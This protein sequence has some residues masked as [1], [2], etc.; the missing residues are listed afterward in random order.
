MRHTTSHTACYSAGHRELQSAPLPSQGASKP[1]ET[2][3]AS[4]GSQVAL[5]VQRRREGGVVERAGHAA[6]AGVGRHPADAVLRLVGRQLPPQLLRQ[7][8]RLQDTHT[9]VA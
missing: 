8:V 2:S 5:A 4:A 6:R 9:G 3:R 1:P 7:D